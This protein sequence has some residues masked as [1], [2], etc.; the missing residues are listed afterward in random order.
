MK[1]FRQ[2]YQRIAWS[3]SQVSRWGLYR[4]NLD[5]QQIRQLF[6]L[7]LDGERGQLSKLAQEA[8]DDVD[9][10]TTAFG[11]AVG[12]TGSLARSTARYGSRFLRERLRRRR[13]PAIFEVVDRLSHSTGAG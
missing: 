13:F 5:Q 2:E 3:V 12:L 8:L 4:G 9:K 11:G 1:R 10:A 7:V 6:E